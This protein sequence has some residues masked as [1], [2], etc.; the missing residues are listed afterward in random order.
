[1]PDI[2]RD[3]RFISWSKVDFTA[4]IATSP[5]L[6]WD[7][8]VMTGR[9]QEALQND[10]I[11][12]K[13]LFLA[14]GSEGETV[15][16]PVERF[17]EALSKGMGDDF[18]YTYRHFPEADH[19]EMPVKSFGY[20]LDFVFGGWQLPGAVLDEGFDR[21]VTH[22]DALSERYGYRI[23]VPE[24]V[25]NRLGY[26]ALGEGDADLAFRI[27]TLNAEEYPESP[28]VW[29]SLAEAYLK[30]GNKEKARELYLKVLKLDPGN[31]NAKK[32]LGELGD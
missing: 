17:R 16:E 1:M 8:E 32:K 12:L 21:V 27:F 23:P 19:Q 15:Q 14:C 26:R 3:R 9:I 6:W 2:L 7:E 24:T 4:Y 11:C 20:G 25:C 30:K 18:R 29:D 5:N 22:Y 13:I 10:A 28:N 31:G